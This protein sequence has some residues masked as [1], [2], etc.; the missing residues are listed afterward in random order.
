MSMEIMYRAALYTMM[1]QMLL[2]AVYRVILLIIMQMHMQ[3]H[4]AELYTI[5]MHILKI[6]Q[7]ILSET[8]HHLIHTMQEAALYTTEV[9]L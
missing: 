5:M 4:M 9:S 7:A 6:F 1:A 3:V 2:L 8:I